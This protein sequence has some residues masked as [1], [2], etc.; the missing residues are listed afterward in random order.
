MADSVDTQATASSEQDTQQQGQ[1]KSFTQEEVNELMGKL[2]RETKS[3]Y[4]DY[5]ALKEK[6]AKLDEIEDAQKTSEEKL[7]ER[8]S[9]LQKENNQLKEQAQHAKLAQK[10]SQEKGVPAHLLTGSTEEEMQS[11]ADA[12][13][14]WSQHKPVVYPK[15]KGGASSAKMIS[16]EDITNTKDR[17]ARVRMRSQHLDLYREDQEF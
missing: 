10:V 7:Q 15:D 12:L 2:R 17:V 14:A 6:A 9:L 13:L 5:D 3:K 4:A 11:C 8:L 1:Q 16:R